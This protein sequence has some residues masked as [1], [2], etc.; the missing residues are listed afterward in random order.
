MVPFPYRP[1][2]DSGK[3]IPPGFWI[4]VI[5]VFMLIYLTNQCKGG[6]VP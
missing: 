4:G 5:L 6:V 2:K 3:P 1:T